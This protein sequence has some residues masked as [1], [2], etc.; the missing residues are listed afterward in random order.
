[1]FLLVSCLVAS[2]TYPGDCVPSPIPSISI[3]K[4]ISGLRQE[5]GPFRTAN[6][7]VCDKPVSFTGGRI[8][9]YIT[10]V[11]RAVSRFTLRLT[12]G[13]AQVTGEKI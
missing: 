12:W 1:M 13:P 7:R 3:G 5:L 8:M 4:L 9:L 6:F 11:R 10:R 2:L